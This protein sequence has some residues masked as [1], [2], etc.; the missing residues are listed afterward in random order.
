MSADQSRDVW[1]V[2]SA[3]VVANAP[4][5][6]YRHLV[7]AAP[8]IAE[9]A[10]PGQFV[11][12]TVGGP[13]SALLLR[14]SF[15]I[16]RAD[17]E[18]GTVEIVVSDAGP[19]TAWIT[20]LPE[21]AVVDVVGPLGRGF[22]VLEGS[23]HAILIGGGYGSAPMFWLGNVLRPKGIQV[24]HI[25]GAA[26]A[27]RLFGSDLAD[28]ADDLIVTTDDGSQGIHGRVTDPLHALL[29]GTGATAV[30]ACGPMAMLRAVTEVATAHGAPA[31]VAVEEAMACGIGVCMTYVL[32]VV[33]A[34]GV[35]RMSRSCVDGPIFDGTAV[36]WDAVA[37]GRVAVPAGCLGAS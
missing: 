31:F 37:D 16:H 21:G 36:R 24:H 7:L 25:L 3:T 20:R 5:A 28:P 22:P 11:A 2:G 34:D 32:P 30:Y 1:H 9:R 6:A 18:R 35:T 4:A 29:D 27:D 13:T 15:S 14:R 17:H 12:L 19:G 10:E 26:T 23:G 8:A 33:G